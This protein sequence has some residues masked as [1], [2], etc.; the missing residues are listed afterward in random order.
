[1]GSYYETRLIKLN[2]YRNKV[3]QT[4]HSSAHGIRF[5]REDLGFEQV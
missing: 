3:D 2:V 5:V 1:M 4:C